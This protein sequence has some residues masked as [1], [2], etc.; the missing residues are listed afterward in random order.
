MRTVQW[1][2]ALSVHSYLEFTP[3]RELTESE[4]TR[5][6]SDSGAA[7]GSVFLLRRIYYKKKTYVHTTSWD[8]LSL[9]LQ[10]RQSAVMDCAVPCSEVVPE[11]II[12]TPERL[13]YR[14]AIRRR[15]A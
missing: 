7:A 5:L 9:R 8:V 14:A 2:L 3:N 12:K 11:N 15:H 13:R 10:W 1:G 6:L 4:K